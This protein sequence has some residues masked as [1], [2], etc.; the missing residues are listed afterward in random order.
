MIAV[1]VM[2]A[3]EVL[4]TLSEGGRLQSE[5]V[6]SVRQS[7]MM[8]ARRQDPDIKARLDAARQRHFNSIVR[9]AVVRQWR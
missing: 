3:N 7:A 4:E 5:I 6:M 8:E 9:L 1:V 2:Q